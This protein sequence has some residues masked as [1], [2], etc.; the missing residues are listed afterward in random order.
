[1][2]GV[3]QTRSSADG[4]FSGAQSNRSTGFFGAGGVGAHVDG[5]RVDASVRFGQQRH[6]FER[7]VNNNLI[8]GGI[9]HA[10]ASF[11]SRWFGV[12]GRVAHDLDMGNGLT[13]TPSFAA[14]YATGRVDGYT[15][16]G[17]TAPAM[18][19]SFRV[20]V[21][22]Y[23]LD[24][25]VSRQIGGGTFSGSLGYVG[26][27]ASGD[28][29]VGVQIFGDQNSV[30]VSTGNYGAAR[31]GLGHSMNLSTHTSVNFGGN[32]LLGGSK[33]MSGGAVSLGVSTRF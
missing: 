33:G 10:T 14:S 18:V 9:E 16:S 8:A 20:S 22:Q 17:V 28:N 24:L 15:E 3:T 4:P 7:V 19:D 31:A 27:N 30:P 26:H 2:A 23:D 11:N 25:A 13:V 1:M 6:S 29:Q 21:L 5:L 32:V 12:A